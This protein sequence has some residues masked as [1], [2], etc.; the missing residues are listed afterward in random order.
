VWSAVNPLL[1][2]LFTI[3]LLLGCS[4]HYCCCYVLLP[5]ESASTV[6]LHKRTMATCLGC[7]KT[8]AATHPVFTKRSSYG[9]GPVR[10]TML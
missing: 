3:Q 6:A 4:M 10:A 5:W 1:A 9:T 2:A 8:T 7:N